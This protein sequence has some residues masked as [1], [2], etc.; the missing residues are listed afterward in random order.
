MKAPID[1]T[2]IDR[3]GTLGEFASEQKP[4]FTIAD[5]STL[6]IDFSVYRRDFSRVHIG[7]AVSID[8]GDGGPPIDARIDYVSPLGASDTQSSMTRAVVA[9]AGRLRPGLF[10]A[11]RVALSARPAEVAIKAT[12]VQSLEGRTVAFVRSGDR[13]EPR[14]LELG[15]RDA[16]WIEVTFGLL[17]G[18]VYAAKNSFVIKAELGKSGASHE[19]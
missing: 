17:A 2:V 11:G 5:L 16:E 13:F 1:G 15:A 3:D 9:N 4:L 14:E 6:W 19:H 8:V 10:V 12:A 18:D 7:D